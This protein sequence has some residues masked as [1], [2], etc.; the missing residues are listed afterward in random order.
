MSV[1]LEFDLAGFG[2][3]ISCKTAQTP[4]ETQ[5]IPAKLPKP[6]PNSDLS[7]IPTPQCLLR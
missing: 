1:G 4:E 3:L 6:R 2:G 5:R 7:A